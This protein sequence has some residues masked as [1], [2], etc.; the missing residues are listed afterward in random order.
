[1]GFPGRYPGGF[2]RLGE[3]V[4]HL[5]GYRD[6]AMLMAAPRLVNDLSWPA[7]L[8]GLIVTMKVYWVVFAWRKVFHPVN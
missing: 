3:T 7:M 1:M 8:A 4:R 5:R 6:L 2:V